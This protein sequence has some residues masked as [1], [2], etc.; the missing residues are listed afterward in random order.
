M[1]DHIA[2]PDKIA[3]ARELLGIYEHMRGRGELLTARRAAYELVGLACQL[4]T[5][6][7]PGAAKING[8]PRP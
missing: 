4:H 2:V 8:A 1:K 7:D 6:A 5:A 3:R